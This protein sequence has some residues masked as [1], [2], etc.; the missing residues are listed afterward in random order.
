MPKNTATEKAPKTGAECGKTQA[1][2]PAPAK[3]NAKADSKLSK[4]SKK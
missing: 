3:K 1:K 2:A 4:G